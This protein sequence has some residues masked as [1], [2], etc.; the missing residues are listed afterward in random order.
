MMIKSM[1][2]TKA[3]NIMTSSIQSAPGG[4]GG[5]KIPQYLFLYSE[6]DKWVNVHASLAGRQAACASKGALKSIEWGHDRWSCAFCRELSQP[7]VDE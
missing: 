1:S 7:A 4:V 2:A 3:H 5:G 6:S